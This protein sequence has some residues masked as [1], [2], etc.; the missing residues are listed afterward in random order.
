[1][2]THTHI[3]IIYSDKRT[4]Q[5]RGSCRWHFL[6]SLT[7]AFPPLS[8]SGERPVYIAAEGSPPLCDRGALGHISV[9]KEKSES[10]VAEAL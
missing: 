1:M 9:G 6:N 4:L 5:T 2:L 3:H 8:S 7:C 10:G